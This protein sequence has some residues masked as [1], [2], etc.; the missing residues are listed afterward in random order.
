MQLQNKILTTYYVG[1][2]DPQ[3]ATE[4]EVNPADFEK[5]AVSCTEKEVDLVI[6]NN[7]FE[8]EKIGDIEY[9]SRPCVFNPYFNRW[10]HYYQYLRD[11]PEIEFAFCVDATDVELINIPFQEMENG[12][13]YCGDEPDF[14]GDNI[15][16]KRHHPNEVLQQFFVDYG[17]RQMINAGVLGGSREDLMAF[18]HNII[19]LFM[20][21]REDLIHNKSLPLGDTD[22]GVFNFVGHKIWNKKLEYG[23]KVT[24][25]FKSYIVD[26]KSWFKHK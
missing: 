1:V 15:W 10:I 9:L 23:R 17:E 24:N 25:V 3:R 19:I 22:M 16:L 26:N 18:I 12:V 6:I 13:I 14:I 20:N 21:N 7:A 5:L 2:N 4:W 11:H 8:N